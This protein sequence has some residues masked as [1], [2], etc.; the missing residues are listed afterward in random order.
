MH[1]MQ[2]ATPGHPV[3]LILREPDRPQLR[4]RDVP[5]LLRRYLRGTRLTKFGVGTNFVSHVVSVKPTA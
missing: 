5:P 4:R 2:Q 1:P 3:N